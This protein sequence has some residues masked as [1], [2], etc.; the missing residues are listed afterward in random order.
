M[1]ESQY[2]FF[3]AAGDNDPTAFNQAN[4]VPGNNRAIQ[5]RK[6]HA[7]YSV[8]FG[9]SDVSPGGTNSAIDTD[10]TICDSANSLVTGMILSAATAFALAF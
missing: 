3:R 1:S 10:K 5:P 6:A 4:A 2:D 9:Q 8:G 7:V